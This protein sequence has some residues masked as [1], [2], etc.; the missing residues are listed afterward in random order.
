MI[1][2]YYSFLLLFP[3]CLQAQ[4]LSIVDA[5][6][7]QPIA[8]TIVMLDTTGYYTNEKGEFFLAGKTFD[9]ISIRHLAYKMLTLKQNKLPDTLYLSPKTIDLGEVELI[10]L[11]KH[12]VKKIK[13]KTIGSIMILTTNVEL[14]SCLCSKKK[15]DQIK[16]AKFIFNIRRRKPD[17]IAASLKIS[18]RLNIY[19]NNDFKPQQ[20]VR[21]IDLS[22][23][24]A[25]GFEKNNSRALHFDFGRNP[26]IVDEKGFCFGLEIMNPDSIKQN[27]DVSFITTFVKRHRLLTGKSHIKFQLQNDTRL[28]E[29]NS[30]LPDPKENYMFIPEIYIYE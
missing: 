21:S 4:K 29:Y 1:K 14:I 9:S 30:I 20:F 19:E 23:L 5:E 28:F 8:H 11:S 7:N 6:T 18:F 13:T 12:T 17:T 16:L 10:D 27:D 15:K 26:L 3:I 22:V 2:F 25:E 24:S